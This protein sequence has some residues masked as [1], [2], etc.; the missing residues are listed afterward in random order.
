M[1]LFIKTKCPFIIIDTRK[2]RLSKTNMFSQYVS[3]K[4]RNYNN[5]RLNSKNIN[6]TLSI[7]RANNSLKIN[8]RLTF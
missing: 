2:A 7:G 1:S 3:I 5:K 4:L 6:S 8:L